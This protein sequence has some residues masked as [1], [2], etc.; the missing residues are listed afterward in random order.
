MAI[1]VRKFARRFRFVAA[2]A[3]K[4]FDLVN[5]RI[6]PFIVSRTET[7]ARRNWQISGL[8]LPIIEPN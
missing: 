8:D 6:A 5:P 1:L 2:L 7:V 4:R 3:Q